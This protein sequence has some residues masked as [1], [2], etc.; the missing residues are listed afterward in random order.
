MSLI[1]FTSL[2]C[3]LSATIFFS[4]LNELKGETPEKGSPTSETEM[5]VSPDEEAF[6]VEESADIVAEH[7]MDGKFDIGV[8]RLVSVEGIEMGG[9]KPQYFD[10]DELVGFFN[11]QKHKEVIV[12]IFHKSMRNHE[13]DMIE[14]AQMN[15]YFKERGYERIVIQQYRA[16]GRP[17]LSDIT[18]D[19]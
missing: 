9:R 6:A 3:A 2:T 15:A 19:P 7:T 12:L 1:S 17:T 8:G 18:T 4:P 11:R 16:F 10:R 5:P 14:V 13:E